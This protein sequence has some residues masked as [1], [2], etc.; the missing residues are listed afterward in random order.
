[1]TDSVTVKHGITGVLLDPPYIAEHMDLNLYATPKTLVAEEC[2]V[3][4]I[5]NGDNPLLRIALCG[6][7]EHDLHMPA[8][9][10]R[11]TW[12]APKGYQRDTG[13]SRRESIWF[14]PH[15]LKPDGG[16][17]GVSDEH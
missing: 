5:A 4:A 17:F 9:W 16:L 7:D 15:C 11:E 12:K 8:G 10:T 14:S 3:W 2:R 13:N 1:M 6:Y